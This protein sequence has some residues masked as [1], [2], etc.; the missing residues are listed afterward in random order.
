MSDQ[1]KPEKD[2]GICGCCGEEYM[3]GHTV[4]LN[5]DVIIVCDACYEILIDMG[6]VN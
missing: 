5:G 4:P 3:Y 1:E 2:L 6:G